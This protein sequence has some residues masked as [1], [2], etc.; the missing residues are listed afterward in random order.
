MS[1]GYMAS[2]SGVDTPAVWIDWQ[3]SRRYA[4]HLTRGMAAMCCGAVC[5]ST[6][7]FKLHHDISVPALNYLTQHSRYRV[8][9]STMT[10]WQN[11]WCMVTFSCVRA[12]WQLEFYICFWI[13]NTK[14]SFCQCCY[15]VKNYAVEWYETNFAL[16]GKE[17][18]FLKL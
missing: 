17:W 6:Q 1:E 13:F 18:T 3:N 15:Q 5:K 14:S 2:Q 9:E 16:F 4:N 11:S 7:S 10:K 12:L 8:K